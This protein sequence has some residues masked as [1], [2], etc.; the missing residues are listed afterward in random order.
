[1][2]F[3]IVCTTVETWNSCIPLLNA[4]AINNQLNDTSVFTVNSSVAQ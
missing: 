1:M 4:L 3:N 2:N